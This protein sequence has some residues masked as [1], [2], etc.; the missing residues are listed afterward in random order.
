M[1][2]ESQERMLI[3]AEPVKAEAIRA[4]CNRWDLESAVVGRLTDDRMLRVRHLGTE[5]IALPI[6]LLADPPALDRPAAEPSEAPGARELRLDELPEPRDYGSA[7]R[8]LVTSPNLSSRHWIYDQYDHYVGAASVLHPGGDAAVVRV[9][10]TDL[11]VAMTVDCNSRYCALDPYVGAC[12]AVC[13]AARNLIAVGAQPLAI[14]DCLNF[15]NPERA[16]VMWQFQQAIAGI[17]DACIALEVPVVSG[18]VSFYTET[19]GKA[20]PP[21]PTIAMVGLL[22]SRVPI[23]PWFKRAGDAILLLG[24]SREELGGSEYLSVVHQKSCGLPPWIDLEAE[25]QLHAVMLA[26][27][28]RSLLQ[29]AHD[30]SDG[31]LAMALVE[32]CCSLP[33]GV[34][35]LGARIRM[36]EGMR[37]D[38]WLFGESQARMLVSV[39]RE[40]VAALRDLGNE[41]GVPATVI[42][43][44]GG[45]TIEL[46]DLLSISVAELAE[47]WREALENM[48]ES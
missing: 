16:E 35:M 46:A 20:I 12:I 36:D 27:I 39:R 15:G 19:E 18:N 38:A 8:Q 43:D 5:V 1:L 40:N 10:G 47:L 41:H 6:E 26:A 2:S 30:L 13:E 23:T 9:L 21:T 24:R 7:L 3:V 31:G 48:L 45:A 4:V 28:E 34:E 32:A 25:R 29:S 17:R 42:G 44:V 33:E 37:P 22:R 11:Q 14:S